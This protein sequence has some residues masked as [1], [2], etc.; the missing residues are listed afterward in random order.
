[1]KFESNS[2]KILVLISYRAQGWLMKI[3]IL[4]LHYHPEPVGVAVYSSEL[5]Q[6]MVKLGHQVNVICGKPFFPNWKIAN[7]HKRGWVKSLVEDGVLV[8]RVAHYVPHKPTGIKRLLHQMTFAAMSFFPTVFTALTMRPD[9]IICIAP[10]LMSAPVGHIAAK[11][12]RAKTWLHIQDF[13]VEAASATQI[14]N[15]SKFGF[16][17]QLAQN[18]ECK[19]L[20]SF[21]GVSA[22]S[23]AMSKKCTSKGV[24]PAKLYE[25]RNWAK[26]SQSQVTPNPSLFRVRFNIHHPFVVLYSGSMGAKQGLEILLH[27]A[28]LLI[29]RKDIC[30]LL[31]GEGPGREKI[32]IAALELQNVKLQNLQPKHELSELL[33]SATVH[34]LPQIAGVSDLVLPS[35]LTNMLASGRPIIATCSEG[36]GLFD[37]VKDCGICVEPGN[38]QDLA[39]AIEKLVDDEELCKSLGKNARLRAETV[40]NFTPIVAKFLFR[41]QELSKA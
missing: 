18:I 16:L 41:L 21:D 17:I 1:L 27:A 15:K 22:I 30:F 33:A 19:I 23:A 32:E 24:L 29:H 37:E 9:I 2:T 10:A 38:A 3:L 6:E 31:C 11:I 28:K 5:A 12:S 7:E 34:L 8:T 36:T 40:W 26:I 25:F 20:R 13:E 4:G 35:K 39:N 14:L